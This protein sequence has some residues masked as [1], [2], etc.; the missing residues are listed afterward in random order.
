M[1]D[2]LRWP[3]WETGSRIGRG[4]FST[5]YEIHREQYGFTERSALKVITIPHNEEEIDLLRV[6]GLDD[7]SITTKFKEKIDDIAKEYRLMIGLKG[8]INVVHCDD[9]LVVKFDEGLGW[10]IYLKMELL[11]PLLKAMDKV[12]SEKQIIKFA[13]DMC[14][15]LA[16]CHKKHVLHRDLK[17]QNIFI[18]E[19]DNFKLGDF[20]ISRTI[21]SSVTEGTVGVG[22]YNYM[23][24]EVRLGSQPYGISAD[25]YSLG[26]V[27]Y[28]LLNERRGPFLPK[29]PANFTA[30]MEEEARSRRFVGEKLPNPSRGRPELIRIVLK[31][32]E[33]DPDKRYQTAREMYSDL[34]KLYDSFEQSAESTTV[35][36]DTVISVKPKEKIATLTDETVREEPIK[37]KKKI[38][39]NKDYEKQKEQHQEGKFKKEPSNKNPVK[40]GF[41]FVCITAVLLVFSFGLGTL[42]ASFL[43]RYETQKGVGESQRVVESGK[44][45]GS[46]QQESDPVT[47][48]EP[49]VNNTEA[50]QIESQEPTNITPI[51]MRREYVQIDGGLDHTV[52]LYSD[53]TVEAIGSNGKGQC[54]VEGWT[55]I[56][57]IS[58][59]RNHTVGLKADGSVVA[60]GENSDGQCDVSGW[61]NIVEIS[62]GDHHTVGLKADGT[63]V[64]T[65]RNQ[66][67]ECDLDS[68]ENLV[69]IGAAYTNTFGLC[70]DGTVIVSGSYRKG[71]IPGWENIQSISVS[72][73]HIVG[74]LSDG[75]VKAVG[76]NNHDQCDLADWR[77][78][79]AVSTGCAYTTGL[80]ADGTVLVKGVND[81]GQYK[82]KQWTGIEYLATGLEHTIGVTEDGNFIAVGANDFEQC[83][84][85]AFIE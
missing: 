61:T 44:T 69:S 39:E 21:S 62:A 52:V 81:V 64:W 67:G 63:V 25:I 36:D 2:N 5:V 48:Y 15:A 17:P 53:G 83:A 6:E 35:N 18:D 22:T 9:I 4:A 10:R 41:L 60:T 77:N 50:A 20:G 45:S 66:S 73:A 75:T 84:V 74:L 76:N 7:E 78:I 49:V 1:S 54:D 12:S 80:K 65:G 79:V 27:I 26:M 28:W 57:Q 46:I 56:V 82:A 13:M 16:F 14:N 3:G 37:P 40:K 59:L 68:W 29:P 47:G 11:T 23:A 32:C 58:T 70:S 24:P 33:Y 72:D 55:D 19:E 8:C 38:Q 43:G 42:A 51:P 85:D 34:K 71:K 30:I 31:A